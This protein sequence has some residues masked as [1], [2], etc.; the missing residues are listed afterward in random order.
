MS[1][2]QLISVDE[3]N[4]LLSDPKLI[5][6]DVRYSL[7]DAAYGRQ[8]YDAG[9]IPGA[10]FADLKTDV[11][12]VR[13]GS[14]G[15]TPLPDSGRFCVNMRRLGLCPESTVVV[16]DDG[17]CTFAARLWFTLRWVGFA[18]VRVLN[19]G[20]AAWKAAGLTLELDEPKW[21]AGTY[22][23]TTPLERVFDDDF[24]ER[25]LEV[26]DYTLVDARAHERYTGE[27]ETYDSKAGHIPGSLNRPSSDN[28][29]PNKLFKT[30]EELKAEF[31]AVLGGVAHSD[32][33]NSCGSGVS[34]C[35]NH[36]AM[37]QAGIP[38]AG[39]YI[40]S[41]SEWVSDD[42]RPIKTGEEP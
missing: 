16:Y 40:G 20:I 27:I 35:C 25:N 24:V 17:D 34:A 38:A 22:R 36:L 8:S 11:A 1:V 31:E 42:N 13:S 14:N 5:L 29:G 18:N 7:N 32:V 10:R 30:P 4:A 28:I 19:G 23:A 12:G 9:H 33:I 15:R 37:M 21:E 39:L 6:L 2:S 41:W 26:G 3:L